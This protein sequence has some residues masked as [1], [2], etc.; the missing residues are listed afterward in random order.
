MCDFISHNRL[1]TDNRI[2]DAM[3]TEVEAIREQIMVNYLAAVQGMAGVAQCASH[4][5]IN[6]RMRR[7]DTLHSRLTNYVGEDEATRIVAGVSDEV[8]AE[9]KFK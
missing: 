5:F 1:A 2:G 9:G 3:E 4:Q 7:I 6:N 8:V